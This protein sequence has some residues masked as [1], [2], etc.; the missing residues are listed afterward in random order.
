MVGLHPG[1]ADD[2]NAG[3]VVDFQMNANMML[4]FYISL[5]VFSI[6]YYWMWKIAYRS[7]IIYDKLSKKII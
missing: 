4:V 3:P 1:S 5:A 6:L 7:I 2:T